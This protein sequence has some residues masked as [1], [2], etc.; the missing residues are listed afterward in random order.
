LGDGTTTQQ[1][2]PEQVGLHAQ[3]S[4]A[5]NSGL[6]GST[7]LV[8]TIDGTLWGW[9]DDSSSQLAEA[10]IDST[11][12]QRTIPGV[13]PQYLGIHAV[14]AQIGVPVQVYAYATSGLPVILTVSGPATLSGHMLL[15]VTA[16]GPVTL[17]GYQPG[18]VNWVSTGPVTSPVTVIPSRGGNGG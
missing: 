12:P 14:T 9:G 2:H 6:S 11:V 15:T 5:S 16:P 1:I 17:M 10:A 4:L 8:T 18:D 13:V 7:S 3:W